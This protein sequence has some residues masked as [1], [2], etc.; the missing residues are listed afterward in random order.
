MM[1]EAEVRVALE[2]CELGA[3]CAMEQID[4]VWYPWRVVTEQGTFVVRECTLTGDQ[5][6]LALEHRLADWL[7]RHDF[8]VPAPL[9]TR[10]GTTWTEADGKLLAVHPYL[11]GEHPRMGDV[12]Q[13]QAAGRALARFHRVAEPFPQARTMSL[14]WNSRTRTPE[15]YTGMVLEAYGTRRNVT[16]LVTE[17]R[18]LGTRLSERSV[19]QTLVHYDFHPGNVLFDGDEFVGLIEIDT[20]HWRERTHDVAK[21]MLNFA[22]AFDEEPN[23]PATPR[24]E[25]DCADAFLRGYTE[26][27]ALSREERELLPLALRWTVRA[28]ALWHLFDVFSELGRWVEHEWRYASLQIPLVEA[29]CA[30]VNRP[31]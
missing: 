2:R 19:I 8:P 24:F 11:I 6:R 4:S 29:Y 28:G 14:P 23:G 18:E 7:K 12:T 26:H 25:T 22:M 17:F 16:E 31:H 9:P 10:Q 30:A 13:A 20:T 1:T 3:P 15:Q 27:T 5:A 21:S